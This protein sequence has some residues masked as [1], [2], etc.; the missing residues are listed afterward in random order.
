MNHDKDIEIIESSG[1]VF[2]DLGLPDAEER[3]IKAEIAAQISRIIENRVLSQKEAAV[4]LGVDQPKISALLR[5]RL[6]GFSIERLFHFLSALDMQVNI[7]IK[8]KEHDGKCDNVR[9]LIA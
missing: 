6:R 3:C 2:A 1:N 5:G 4:L 7:V 9:V 8:S